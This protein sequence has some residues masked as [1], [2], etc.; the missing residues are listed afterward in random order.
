MTRILL[1]LLALLA[2]AAP[3]AAADR[4]YP[5]ADFDRL[6]IEGPYRVH[7]VVGRPTTARANGTRLGLER[8]SI[9]SVGQTLRIRPQRN[10]WGADAAADPG[11][12][13]IELTTRTLRSARLLGPAVLDVEGAGGLALDLMVEGSGTLRATRVAAETLTL[14]LQGAGALEVAGTAETL[15]GQFQGTGNVA[16]A[17]LAADAATITANTVGTV[18]LRVN[19]RAEITAYGLGTVAVGGTPACV[20]SGPGAANV[21]CGPGSEQGQ[22]R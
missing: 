4:S 1:A 19:G 13:T 10:L 6:V 20:L 11:P 2:A 17:N 22:A 18:A 15:R 12:V 21:R 8:V 3:A 14:G 9:E 7:L 5:V 16:A